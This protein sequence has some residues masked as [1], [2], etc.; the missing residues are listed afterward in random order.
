MEVVLLQGGGHLADL[1]YAQGSGPAV[2]CLWEAPWRTV[3]PDDADHE[4]LAARYGSN[5]SGPFLAG[6]TGHALCLDTFGAP[7]PEQAA[8]GAS[9]HGEAAVRPW[10]I[11]STEQGCVAR[12]YLP[13]AQLEFERVLSLAPRSTVLFV[14]ERVKN[15][16]SREREIHWVQHLAFGPPFLSS[17]H[18]SV[19]ASLDRAMTW[20]LGYESHEM[21]PDNTNFD[22]PIAPSLTGG[23]ISLER[24]F[25]RR[26]RGFV[27]AARVTPGRDIGFVAALN[28][29][30]GMALVYCFR[31]EDFPWIAVWEENCARSSDP[32]K[33]MTQVRGMEFGTTPM[34]LGHEA[35]RKMG[36][37]FDTPGSRIVAASGSLDARYIASIARI[38][39]CWDTIT[40][41][42]PTQHSLTLI[43]P[44]NGDRISVPA[45]GLLDF[46]LK[47]STTA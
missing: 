15:R 43:G 44:R 30:L 17:D 7:S 25:Q 45:E 35:I 32:W 14:S 3:D 28:Q 46:L 29:E 27:V 37:L 34:P 10:Q 11:D 23:E 24:P 2:N 26:G 13:A 47:G 1:R 41:I 33:G 16:G 5:P 4:A 21:L 6:Y 20:P 8:L 42:A 31:R 18:C 40:E 9:L 22:W 19:H 12:V 38:P 36:N 39:A